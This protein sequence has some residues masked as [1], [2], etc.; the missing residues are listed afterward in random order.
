MSNASW[1]T[2]RSCPKCAARFYDLNQHPALCPKCN[3]SFDPVAALKPRRGR[4][5]KFSNLTPETEAD[6]ALFNSIL[7]KASPKGKKGKDDEIE[8]VKDDGLV[9]D[10]EEIDEFENLQELESI[11]EKSDS[12]D[13]A[14]E[15]KIME[16]FSLEGEELVDDIE[17]VEESGDDDDA[18][19]PAKRRR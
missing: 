17:E 14:D 5:R 10:A 15:E 11:E 4:A 2:K 6:D 3:H 8:D 18:P 19:K 1:G 16:E 9:E 13:E 7:A 12:G